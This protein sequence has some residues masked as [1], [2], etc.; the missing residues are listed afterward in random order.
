MIAAHW[1]KTVRK[2]K[3]TI[4]PRDYISFSDV[5]KP[6]LDR[7]LK[8][9]AEPVTN[10][11]QDRVLRIFDAGNVMEFIV[12]RALTMAGILN[13]KQEFVEIPSSEKQLKQLGF[14]DAT[15]GGFVDWKH[16]EETIRQ[17][18]T[19]YKLSLDDQLLEQKAVNI[20]EGLSSEY[21]HG[22]IPEMLIEVKSINSMAFWAHKNR[23]E[24]GNFLGY[25]HNKLQMYGYMKATGIER[26]LLVY[27]SKDD[28]VIEEIALLLGDRKLE[29]MYNT[30]VEMM[31]E[32]YKTNIEPPKEEDVVWNNRKKTFE[33]N[34]RLLRS[35]YLTRI[36]GLEK[37]VFEEQARKKV[38]ELNLEQKWRNQA[39]E[40]GFDVTE[41]TTKEIKKM[42]MARNRELKKMMKLKQ[43]A[44]GLEQNQ[45]NINKI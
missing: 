28:F 13:K 3:P 29:E 23:D 4:K 27:I 40:Y 2:D 45:I 42:C 34:W 31:T 22:L 21:K 26:G 19:E 7:Y 24:K 9:K 14:L 12:L 1:N 10:P 36:T 8:M 44:E 30:D 35:N 15:I 18:L 37:E 6:F 16:A 33:I 39:K 5:G 25:E 38:N 43:E 17:H 11:F 41:L 32:Y 20:I